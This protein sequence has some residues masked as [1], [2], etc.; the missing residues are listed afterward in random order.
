MDYEYKYLK[1]KEKY[2][3][4]KYDLFM[5][6]GKSKS[7]IN[8]VYVLNKFNNSIKLISYEKYNEQKYKILDEKLITSL[9]N[10]NINKITK[11]IKNEHNYKNK[12]YHLALKPYK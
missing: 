5:T 3:H 9:I 2:I 1:Y 10:K 4:L 11:T 12:Y 6:G 8:L 7:F